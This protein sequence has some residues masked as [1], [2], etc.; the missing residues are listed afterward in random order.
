MRKIKNFR[1]FEGIEGREQ[2]IYDQINTMI[3]ANQ[4]LDTISQLQ[5]KK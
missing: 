1:L 2:M 3:E 5:V 4:S